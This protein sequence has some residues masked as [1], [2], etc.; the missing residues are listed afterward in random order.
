[1]TITPSE[2]FTVGDLVL[3]RVRVDD[4]AVI[5]GTLADNWERLVACIRSLGDELATV[6]YQSSRLAAVHSGWDDGLRYEY[7]A[8]N[9]SPAAR[10]LS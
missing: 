6:Q 3:R 7:V 9:R 8:V 2:R 5:A 4:A 1:M 10:V